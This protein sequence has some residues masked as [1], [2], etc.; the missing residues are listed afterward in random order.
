MS[1]T[2]ENKKPVNGVVALIFDVVS[3]RQTPY[4]PPHEH[5]AKSLQTEPSAFQKPGWDKVH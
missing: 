2:N 1:N 3:I 4:E 5:H